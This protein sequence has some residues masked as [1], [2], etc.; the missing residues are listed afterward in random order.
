M[1]DFRVRATIIVAL[2]IGAVVGGAG[3]WSAH[4]PGPPPIVIS[5]PVGTSPTPVKGAPPS[6][7]PTAAPPLPAPEPKYYVHVAGAVRNPSL[8]L[9]PPG[10]RV[11]QA[12]KAAGGPTSKADLDA[13]NLAEK[14]KDG[15]KV[16]I[17]NKSAAASPPAM[18]APPGNSIGEGSAAPAS[19]PTATDSSPAT[20]PAPPSAKTAKAAGA[21]KAAKLSSP[22]QG[23]VDINTA[24]AAQLQRLPGIGPA[25]AAR[26]L[27]YRQQAGGFQKVEELQEI[28]GIG[29]KKYAK[30][31]PLVK[32]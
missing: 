5:G 29:P 9:L 28:S 18:L 16:Y 17:P 22:A 13:V 12:I 6:P 10:S 8:Y 14:V 7:A 3:L 23:Q 20:T 15:E 30:L 27:A 19:S 31:A 32:L 4:R 26:V 1:Q 2:L 24:T 25:M 11:M 21:G